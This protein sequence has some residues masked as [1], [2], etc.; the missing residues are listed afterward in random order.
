LSIF[1]EARRKGEGQIMCKF[2]SWVERRDKTYFLTGKQIF[3][4]AG[5]EKLKRLGVSSDDY[6]GHGTIRAWYKID[7]GDGIDKECADFSSPDNFP[8]IIATAIKTGVME[9]LG[10]E[11]ALLLK[12]ALAEYEKI[13]QSAWAEYKKIEQP[14]WAEYERIRQPASA[15]YKKIEQSAWAEYKKIKQPAWAEYE[16]IKQ[17]AFWGLFAKLENRIPAWK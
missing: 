6:R 15:E 3:S 2:I 8:D 16:K 13:E 5:Q 10:I 4:D 1:N 17:S 12:P 7:S 9:G 14:A 11:T